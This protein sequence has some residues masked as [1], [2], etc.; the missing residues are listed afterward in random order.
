[1]PAK[2]AKAIKPTKADVLNKLEKDVKVSMLSSLDK[3]MNDIND[4]DY[5]SQFYFSFVFPS[6]DVAVEFATA[7]SKIIGLAED[8]CKDA[9]FFDGLFMAEKLGIKLKT[10]SFEKLH[11]NDAQTYAK[12]KEKF[13]DLCY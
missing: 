8:E 3:R 7:M 1:M 2:P 6:R 9:M 4:Y 5:D 10:K 12:Y 13:G 11:K